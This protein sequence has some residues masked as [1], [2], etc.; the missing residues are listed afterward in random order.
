MIMKFRKL[1]WAWKR[2]TRNVARI[3]MEKPVTIP[4][5]MWENNVKKC[6]MWVGCG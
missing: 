1:R 6:V 5:K 3:F 4:R 2:E